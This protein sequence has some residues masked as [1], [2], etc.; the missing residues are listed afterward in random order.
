VLVGALKLIVACVLVAVAV[1]P[2]AAPGAE[3]GVTEFDAVD[4]VL[5]PTAFVAVTVKVYAVPVFNPVMMIGDEPPVAVKPP[6]LEVT[7]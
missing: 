2:V 3:T 4:A 6:T 5:V 7:V 1:T